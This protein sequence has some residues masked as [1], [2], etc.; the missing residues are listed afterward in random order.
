MSDLIVSSVDT[1]SNGGILTEL[2]NASDFLPR[3]QLYG[4]KSNA[5]TEGKIPMAHYG[6]ASG[7]EIEDLGKEIDVLV[8]A[9]RPKALEI[10][11]ENI[12]STF[13][14][15][16]KEFER[17]RDRSSIKDSGCMYGPEYLLYVPEADKY[18]T[19]FMASKSLRKEAKSI[20]ARLRNAAHLAVKL[21]DSGQYKWHV[22]VVSDPAVVPNVPDPAAID[23]EIKKFLADKGTQVEKVTNDSDRER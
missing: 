5:V 10:S 13:D 12:I 19:W 3:L 14:H 22:P 21:A 7:G 6:L 4:A 1:A 9:G 23:K 15:T 8:L 11:G 2:A 18:C 16:S 20:Q 17:I